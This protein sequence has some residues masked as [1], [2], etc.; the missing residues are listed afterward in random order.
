MHSADFTSNLVTLMVA[1]GKHA[2]RSSC[3]NSQANSLKCLKQVPS[4]F[5]SPFG[6]GG[7]RQS[8]MLVPSWLVHT[9]AQPPQ[10]ASV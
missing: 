7:E 4:A 9:E 6:F 1:A 10:S 3:E 5:R 2:C 8:F